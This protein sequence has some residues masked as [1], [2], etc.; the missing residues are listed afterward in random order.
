MS[1]QRK[2]NNAPATSG[3]QQI[4][5][6]QIA[7][8]QPHLQSIAPAPHQQMQQMQQ[9]PGQPG[10]PQPGMQ[11]QAMGVPGGHP[12]QAQYQ[13]VQQPYGT[14]AANGTAQF[15]MQPMFNQQGQLILQQ[16]QF[17]QAGMQMQPGQQQIIFTNVDPNQQQKQGQQQ[18]LAPQQQ[19]NGKPG[20]STA[21]PQP[22]QGQYAIAQ[23]GQILTAPGGQPQTYMFAN[24]AMQAAQV[25]ANTSMAA[26]Q[27]Q[28]QL[29][30]G[31]QQPDQKPQLPQHPTGHPT[32]PQ[33]QQMQSPFVVANGMTYVNPQT[34]IVQNGQIILRTPTTPGDPNAANAA[35][36]PIMFSPTGATHMQPGMQATPQQQMVATSMQQQLGQ[37]GMQ[38]MVTMPMTSQAVGIRPNMATSYQQAPPGKTAI[39]RALPT[40]LPTT[41]NS[42][43]PGFSGTMPNLQTLAP[44]PQRNSPKSNKSKTSPRGLIGRPPGPSKT[45]MNNL[46]MP[47]GPTNMGAPRLPGSPVTGQRPPLGP[48]VLQTSQGLPLASMTSAMP[49]TITTPGVAYSNPPTLQPMMP[50]PGVVPSMPI[51]TA[52]APLMAV[53]TSMAPV[54]PTSTGVVASSASTVTTG[55]KSPTKK[56]TGTTS[57]P[58]PPTIPS[59]AA[60]AAGVG[61]KGENGL[62]TPKAVVKPNML[63]HI[64]DGLVINESSTPFPIDREE[65]GRPRINYVDIFP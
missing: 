18:M 39:S 49:G 38:P 25:A 17:L 41:T 56:A 32:T 20:A 58:P 15:A 61:V 33:Q 1:Q 8:M 35:G 27:A 29:K 34:A 54:P 22:Q 59:T 11:L 12:Q 62:T 43:R 47:T 3:A 55:P 21:Q 31:Q 24:P 51:L 36:T 48:P 63:T 50:A 57:L 5:F 16:G 14:M 13:I 53:N 10:Q 7:Q 23:G 60:S 52:S 64:I 37:P 9:Q 40:L 26:A 42:V 28:Q 6:Q 19:Q 30:P 44:T 45:A 65:K 4:Q 46:K 2:S